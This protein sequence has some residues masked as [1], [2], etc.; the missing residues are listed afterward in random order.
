MTAATV[1]LGEASR[2]LGGFLVPR[3]EL[4]LSG[5]NADPAVLRDYIA[6]FMGILR[7]EGVTAGCYAHASVGCIHVKPVLNLKQASDVETM[8]R[9]ADAVGD[10]A[11]AGLPLLASFRSSRGGHKLNANVLKA[12]FAD[13]NAWAVV[14]APRMREQFQVGVGFQ[15]AAAGE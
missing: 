2:R 1:T 13:Q 6:E 4:R 15:A 8:R 3:F 9:I 5:E 10:L 14:Q 11:L 7:H 12:M